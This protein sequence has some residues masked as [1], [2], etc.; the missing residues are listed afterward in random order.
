MTK[1]NA[2]LYENYKRATASELWEV[3]GRHS[4]AKEQAMEYCRELQYNMNGWGGR[5]CS[6]NTFQFSYA[7]RYTNESGKECLAYITRDNNRYFE[8]EE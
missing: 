6:A 7:F 3:Y 4:R 5:I 2:R 1:A 8:I